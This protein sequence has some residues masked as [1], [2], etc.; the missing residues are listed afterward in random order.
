MNLLQLVIKQMRQRA[1]S[2]WL[3]MLSVTL[4][5]ALAIAVLIIYRQGSA[6]FV[7]TDFGYDIIAGPP[8]GSPLQLVLNTVYQV[9]VSPGNI[10]YSVYEDLM[11][12]R[13]NAKIVIPYAVGDSFRNHRI[14]GTLP[15]LFGVDEEGKPLDPER[16]FEYRLGR[17]YEL[18][19]GRAFHPSKFEAVIGSD[20]PSRTGLRLGD[21]FKATHGMPKPGELPDEHAQTWTVVGILK[22]TRTAADRVLFIPLST[23]Y[24]IS[25]HEEGLSQQADLKAGVTPAPREQSHGA[26]KMH[27]DGT[28]ELTLPKEDWQLSAVLVKARSSFAAN[29]LIYYYKMIKP[30]AVAVNPASVMREFFETFFA[31]SRII[32]LSIAV[33]VNVVA[34]AG[35]LVSIYNSIAARKREIAILRALGATRGKV[36]ALLCAEAAIIGVIGAVLGFLIAHAAAGVASI[37][38]NRWLG[39]S[40][41]W[42]SFDRFEMLYLLGVVALA[43]LAGLVPAL[44]AYRTPVATNL[45][46]A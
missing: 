1:L 28:I 4:G 18:A 45:V 6:L 35:I 39:Q 25:E 21:T 36:L 24:A 17:R 46:A 27:D 32:L 13:Q 15:K 2:T 20:I 34:A 40:V 9:D 11:K 44:K 42:L 29:N 23:F 31:P 26:Y 30:D 37:Y 43:A 5:V 10:P 33:L 22:P 12:N 3:T 7:Q 41:N 38:L 8:K 19:D 16:V 14:I